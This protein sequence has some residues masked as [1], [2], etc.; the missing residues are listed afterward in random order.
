MPYA[1]LLKQEMVLSQ[2][3]QNPSNNSLDNRK[4]PSRDS[5]SLADKTP[6][7]HGDSKRGEIGFYFGRC[8]CNLGPVLPQLLYALW[9]A[10]SELDGRSGNGRPQGVTTTYLKD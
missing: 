6:S 3:R 5:R 8:H 9:A 2:I 4:L 7:S 10:I 1:P